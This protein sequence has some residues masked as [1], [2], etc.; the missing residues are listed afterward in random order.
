MIG[1]GIGRFSVL[2]TT[3]RAKGL[4]AKRLDRDPGRPLRQLRD[5]LDQ[6]SHVGLFP[7][8]RHLGSGMGRSELDRSGWSDYPLVAN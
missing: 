3:G 7:Y 6:A 2:C 1:R 5:L 8:F 4:G